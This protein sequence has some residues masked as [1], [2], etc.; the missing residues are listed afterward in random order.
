MPL[1]LIL[2]VS[3]LLPSPAW[4]LHPSEDEFFR[5]S[6]PRTS[7][8]VRKEKGKEVKGKGRKAAQEM[9]VGVMGWGEN[10]ERKQAFSA[11]ESTLGTKARGHGRVLPQT[12]QVS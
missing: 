12:T 6:S 5:P 9:R 10:E 8:H 4:I 1:V 11:Q 3:S 7:S 2:K